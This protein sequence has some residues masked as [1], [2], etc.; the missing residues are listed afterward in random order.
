MR[1]YLHAYQEAD[2]LGLE[3][4]DKGPPMTMLASL[5]GVF[6]L[7]SKSFQ[8]TPIPCWEREG[9]EYYVGISTSVLVPISEVCMASIFTCI[10]SII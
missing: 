7:I 3:T 4:P 10:L 6:L 5:L 9:L 2:H 1:I 8:A